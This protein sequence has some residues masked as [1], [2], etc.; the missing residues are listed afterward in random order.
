VRSDISSLVTAQRRRLG[1][2]VEALDETEWR[3]PSL[4][5]GWCVRDVVAHCV[6]SH[7]ATPSR[8]AVE[9]L[10]AR[11]SLTARNERWVAARRQHDRAMVLAEYRASA[12]RV[13]VPA[14]ELPYAL[15]EAVVHGYDIAC[16]TRQPIEV[17]TQSLVI[18][19]DACR[20]AGLFLHARQRCAGLTLRARDA[21]WS[22]GSGPEV[23]GPLASIVMAIT[24]RPVAL[25]GLSGDGLDTLRSRV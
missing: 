8:L 20:R 19:A 25:D 4:Y 22:A 15:T 9:L 13:N 21:D 18:V 17:P 11:L 2:L 14:A 1:R 7:V 16:P 6:Q 23:T 10:A 5:T 3:G 24:G 12:D